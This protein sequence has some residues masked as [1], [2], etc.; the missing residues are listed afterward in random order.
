MSQTVKIDV[1]SDVV[2]PWCYIG[3]RNLESGVAQFAESN[4]DVAVEVEYH[5]FELS[6]DTPVDFEGGALEY[7]KQHR[8]V[9]DEIARQMI[10]RVVGIAASVGLDYDYGSI[11]HTNTVKAHQVLHLAKT[12][13][14]QDEMKE[15]LLRAY[16]IEGLH[17]GE[18]S[19]LVRLAA[20]VGLD[21]DAVERALSEETFLTAV[22]DDQQ[23]AR[24]LGISGVPFFVFN[25]EYGLS[26]AQPPEAF[27]EILGKSAS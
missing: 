22:R 4:P 8:Q 6:P 3:K 25:M 15:R 5:S 14:L 12:V 23:K 7:L 11:Q 18:D 1:W 2:C 16:F 17:I 21:T 10:D 9:P 24:E 20:E 13:G 19:D 27:V 26:G